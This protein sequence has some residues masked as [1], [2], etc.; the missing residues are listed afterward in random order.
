MT[1]QKGSD[2]RVNCSTV[3]T[4][5]IDHSSKYNTCNG[6]NFIMC[7]CSNKC[8]CSTDVHCS[9]FIVSVT[10]CVSLYQ[11]DLNSLSC[12]AQMLQRSCPCCWQ[13]SEWQGGDP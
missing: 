1:V 4:T 12:P 7:L 11:L 9:S 8:N 5:A 10:L 13:W 3:I 6:I 2:I